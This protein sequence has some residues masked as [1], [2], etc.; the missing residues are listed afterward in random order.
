LG[1]T[2][3]A[4]A[5]AKIGL[6]LRREKAVVDYANLKCIGRGK[7]TFSTIIIGKTMQHYRLFLVKP[8]NAKITNKKAQLIWAQDATEAKLLY[9]ERH[10]LPR[11]KEISL[12]V[13]EF[14][15]EQIHLPEEVRRLRMPPQLQGE[16]R[17]I[18]DANG[19]QETF[20]IPYG[21][22]AGSNAI[23]Y[24]RVSTPKQKHNSSF[25]RQGESC[26]L[27]A[28]AAGLNV[29]KHYEEVESGVLYKG[30]PM[31]QS[32]LEDI[33]CGRAKVLLV[34]SMDRLL[35]DT[36][37]NAEIPGR[38]EAAGGLLIFSE[39]QRIGSPEHKFVM[40]TTHNADAYKRDLL[41]LFNV[42][43]SQ[44]WIRTPVN[45]FCYAVG[46]FLLVASF[47]NAVIGNQVGN[48]GR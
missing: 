28:A 47:P 4:L 24:A 33:E 34:E 22:E 17:V 3:G 15:Q 37:N 45:N 30:R 18:N 20:I 26:Q 21:L 6:R 27:F 29:V 2:P 44:K 38:I 8:A 16:E 11:N 43:S 12:T 32:A 36:E 31:L 39:E 46:I 5:W 42:I 13:I 10:D 35:R 9:R 25:G 41:R 40:K 48:D 23:I 14:S 1:T 7:S 19:N